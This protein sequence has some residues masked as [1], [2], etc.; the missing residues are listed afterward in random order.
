MKGW[1]MFYFSSNKKKNLLLRIQI[2]NSTTSKKIDKLLAEGSNSAFITSTIYEEILRALFPGKVSWAVLDEKII[3][4]HIGLGMRGD[5]P[6]YEAI[7]TKISQ[8]VESGIA[9]RIIEYERKQS[10]IK[11]LSQSSH[12]SESNDKVQL[13]LYHLGTWFYVLLLFSAFSF[14]VFITEFLIGCTK[15]FVTSSY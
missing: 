8:L 13:T 1:Q 15:M 14:L 6:L 3:S 7:N 5:N 12:K 11:I 4:D 10:L 9:S 2:I